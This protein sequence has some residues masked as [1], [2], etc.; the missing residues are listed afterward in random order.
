VDRSYVLAS[1]YFDRHTSYVALSRHRAKAA[2]FYDEEEFGRRGGEGGAEQSA[3]ARRTLEYTLARARPKELAHDYL[4]LSQPLERRDAA[5][6]APAEKTS[7]LA[8]SARMS[9]EEM[10][11]LGREAWAA[12][13]AQR[14]GAGMSVEAMQRAARERW[15]AYREGQGAEEPKAKGQ[16]QERSHGQDDD[17]SL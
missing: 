14:S 4:D 16:A 9:V 5:H 1:R 13:R 12:L 11:A 8:Q 2:V 7:R 10:Q 17:Q 6:E 15:Q 3:L